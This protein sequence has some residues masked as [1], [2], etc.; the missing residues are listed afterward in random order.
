MGISIFIIYILD[1]H[2]EMD[3]HKAI[4]IYII[5]IYYIH[6]SLMAFMG[7]YRPPPRGPGAI[8]EIGPG[9]GA[10]KMTVGTLPAKQGSLN[11]QF[12][13]L[14]ICPLYIFGNK[15][16]DGTCGSKYWFPGFGFDSGPNL[17]P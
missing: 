1:T 7:P 8:G 10:G 14:Q 15:A 17:Q 16:T 9:R 6:T 11:Y 4:Y 13:R 12:S 5:Y 3:I 2:P